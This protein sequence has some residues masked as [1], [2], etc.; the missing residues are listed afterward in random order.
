VSGVLEVAG[1]QRRFGDRMV[2]DSVDL[3]VELGERVALTGP[4]GAGKTTLLRCVSGTLAPSGGSVLIGGHETGSIAA[5]RLIGTS[6]SLERSM[7]LRLRGRANLLFFAR[8]RVAGEAGARAEVDALV[9]ELELGEI[10]A[11]RVDSCSTGMLQQLAIARALIGSPRLLLLDEPT[12]S[13]DTEAVERLWAALDRRPHLAL[14]IAT[15]RS[16]DVDRCN[17]RL[18]L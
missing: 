9:D 3:E 10:V 14:V 17:A 4:N 12:R 18:E 2:L 1:L 16:D 6:L 7:Y 5:K 11:K 8:L 15:H 13:L